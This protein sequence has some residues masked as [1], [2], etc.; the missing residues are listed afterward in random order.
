MITTTAFCEWSRKPSRCWEIIFHWHCLSAYFKCTITNLK[1]DNGFSEN[2]LFDSLLTTK[3]KTS[4]SFALMVKVSLWYNHR[5]LWM[6]LQTHRSVLSL[7][8]FMFVNSVFHIIII[9]QTARQTQFPMWAGV[10]S[11][12]YNVQTLTSILSSVL[13]CYTLPHD[14]D[15]VNF[16]F[17]WLNG[18]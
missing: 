5:W 18:F 9:L 7:V 13:Q 12:K 2:V 6:E 1:I 3:Q 10:D 17:N 14:L 15:Y 11:E 16:L 4:D 8:L